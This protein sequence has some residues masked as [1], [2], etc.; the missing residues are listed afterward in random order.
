MPLEQFLHILMEI[1]FPSASP[2]SA[3]SFLGNPES[4]QL[5]LLKMLLN[6]IWNP[7]FFGDFEESLRMVEIKQKGKKSIFKGNYNRSQETVCL[8]GIAPQNTP[9]IDC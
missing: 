4:L 7:L 6:V 2:S 5:S 8:P 3:L 9:R 1:R